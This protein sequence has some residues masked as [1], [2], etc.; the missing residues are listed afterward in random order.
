[1]DSYA[2]Y[3]KQNQRFQDCYSLVQEE[4]DKLNDMGL[5]D[6]VEWPD[7]ENDYADED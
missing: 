4:E 5:F 1:M 3:E 7:D 2:N 6:E